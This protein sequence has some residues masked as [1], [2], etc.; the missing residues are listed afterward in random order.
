MPRQP[1]VDADEG[2]RELFDLWSAPTGDALHRVLVLHQLIRSSADAHEPFMLLQKHHETEPATS[3]VTAL[4]LLTDMRWRKGASHLVRRIAD[5]GILDAEQLDVLSRSF[6]MADDALYWQV[7]DEWLSGHEIAIALDDPALDDDAPDDTVTDEDGPM[8]TRREVFPP[9]RRWAAAHLVTERP[10]AWASL[11]A[12]ARELDARSGAA[13]AAGLLDQI[14]VL[15]PDAQD[16]L[17]EEMTSWPDKTVRRLALGFIAERDGAEAA[18]R[19]GR[20]DP[21]AQIRSWAASLL[22]PSPPPGRGTS[23]GRATMPGAERGEMPALF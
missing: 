22:D 2:F 1:L 20:D 10:A 9:L 23:T 18:C 12:R 17:V 15:T 3:L 4:L 7:P 16:F 11:L 13:V 5:C 6:L 21:N 14:D 19:L 8:V